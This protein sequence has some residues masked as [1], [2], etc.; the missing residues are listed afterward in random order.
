MAIGWEPPQ[1]LTLLVGQWYVASSRKNLEDFFFL[2]FSRKQKNKKTNNSFHS[3]LGRSKSTT[4][5]E[6]RPCL[7]SICQAHLSK[8]HAV[9]SDKIGSFPLPPNMGNTNQETLK[10]HENNTLMPIS[11]QN[12]PNRWKQ[13]YLV[14]WCVEVC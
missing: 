5:L 6:D 14:K 9:Y 3:I 11:V 1:D 12:G 8:I 4:L 7:T 13:R 10:T 2:H